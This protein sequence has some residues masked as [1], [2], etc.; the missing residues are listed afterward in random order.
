MGKEKTERKS[1]LAIAG[2]IIAI[3]SLVMS[4]VPI[5]NNVMFFFALIAL[6]FGIIG[7]VSV[8]KGKRVGQGLAI[9][10]IIIS[11][12]AGVMVLA[13]QA[14][15]GAMIDSVGDAVSE[16]VDDFDGTNTD[17]LLKS[18]VDV[19]IGK[20]AVVEKDY[21]EET[22]LPVTITNKSDEKSGFTVKIEALDA[23]GSRIADDTIYVSDLKAGQSVKEK[24]FEFVD[25]SKVKELKKATFK[26][27]EVSK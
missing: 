26:V 10:T 21:S 9:A 7:L 13:S 20:F 15:Y 11:A 18:S 17:K 8:K 14:F 12:V 27:L 6:V 24:A 4:W 3:F 23:D 2:L 19:K 25:S 16:S 1:G 5:V 22:K